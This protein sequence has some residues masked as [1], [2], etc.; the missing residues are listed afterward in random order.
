MNGVGWCCQEG[1]ARAYVRSPS[2]RLWLGLPAAHTHTCPQHH[3][4]AVIIVPWDCGLYVMG[5]Y[6]ISAEVMPWEG[7]RMHHVNWIKWFCC[8]IEFVL[9]SECFRILHKTSSIVFTITTTVKLIRSHLSSTIIGRYSLFAHVIYS[10]ANTLVHKLW[11]KRDSQIN[12]S[13]K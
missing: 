8:N 1:R 4:T 7:R 6:G 3:V 5:R 2:R 9:H 11:K 13:E 10:S 12:Y